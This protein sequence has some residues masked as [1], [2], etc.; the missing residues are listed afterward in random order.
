MYE[1]DP[2]DIPAAYAA[3]TDLGWRAIARQAPTNLPS[4]EKHFVSGPFDKE[5][6]TVPRALEAPVGKRVY[7]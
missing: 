1:P 4:I 5:L 3:L 2:E 7:S 6:K